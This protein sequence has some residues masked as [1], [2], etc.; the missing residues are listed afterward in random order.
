M[1]EIVVEA[2]RDVLEKEGTEEL[3][4][5]PSDLAGVLHRYADNEKRAREDSAWAE[6]AANDLH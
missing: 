5:N 1:S 6:R 2:L 3:I 4:Q